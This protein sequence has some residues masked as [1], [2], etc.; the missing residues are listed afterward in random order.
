MYNPNNNIE[1][2]E[3]YVFVDN[4][5]EYIYDD[6]LHCGKTIFEYTHG[7]GVNDN[8]LNDFYKN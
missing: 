6:T 2:N 4:E 3:E 5:N 7:N 1:V 8:I